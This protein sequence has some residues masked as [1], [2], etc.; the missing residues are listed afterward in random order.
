MTTSKKGL[1]K[2]VVNQTGIYV[3]LAQNFVCG[4]VEDMFYTKFEVSSRLLTDEGFV[5]EVKSLL[6]TIQARFDPYSGMLKAS[7]EELAQGVAHVIHELTN[8]P[9]QILVEVENMTGHVRFE[10]NHGEAKPNFPR[11]ATKAEINETESAR[12]EGRPRPSC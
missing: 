9:E 5:T 6:D 12:R 10:W 4:G 8:E 11:K 7:C 1:N 2:L 3:K